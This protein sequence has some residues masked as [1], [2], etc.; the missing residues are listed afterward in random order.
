MI[1][2]SLGYSF[3]PYAYELSGGR[4]TVTG[5]CGAWM[6]TAIVVMPVVLWASDVFWRAVDLPSV[7]FGKWLEARLIDS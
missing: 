2:R 6:F 7:K 1:I 4:E 3:I 5:V